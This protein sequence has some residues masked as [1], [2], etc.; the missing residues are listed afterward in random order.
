MKKLLFP[1]ACLLLVLYTACNNGGKKEN[2]EGPVT[3]APKTLADS[4][5]TDVMDGHDAGM[6]KYGKMQGMQ[7]QVQAAI[8]SISKLPAKAQQ[9]AAGYRARLDSAAKDLG[10]AIAAMDNWME[11]FNMDSALDNMQERIRYLTDE[12]MKVGKVKE[13]IMNS[14]QR[15]DS[16]LKARF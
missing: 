4:L 2:K 7:K 13:A 1:A 9:A 12:K 15:A 16:L 14:L 5:M 6:S 8:D 10:Y 3:E 11:T